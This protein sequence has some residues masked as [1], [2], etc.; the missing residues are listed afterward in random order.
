MDLEYGGVDL[1][2]FKLLKWKQALEIFWSVAYSLT[3][4]EKLYQ[5]EHRDLHWGNIVIEYKQSQ[6]GSHRLED[7]FQDL[8]F[9]EENDDDEGPTLSQDEFSVKI[10]DYTLSRLQSSDGSVIHTRLDHQ[11][12]FK[13][14]GDYQFDIYRMMRSELKSLQKSEDSEVDWS[15]S[16]FRT[17]LMWLH[18]LLDKLVRSKGITD[19]SGDESREK[20]ERLLRVLNPRRKKLSQ[21]DDSATQDK[22]FNDFHCCEDVLN[23]G[24][25]QGLV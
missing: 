17:N 13:G 5:F 22:Y 8:S 21:D 20:L 16:S 10:I 6:H 24:K 3:R 11:D 14:R 4:A 25:E 2:H 23:Y 7:A 15:L 19:L 12:F 9:I 1:E 18:Y